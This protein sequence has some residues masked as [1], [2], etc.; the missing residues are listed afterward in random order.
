LATEPAVCPPQRT[1]PVNQ[2]WV[3]RIGSRMTHENACFIT[4]RI[5]TSSSF[6]FAIIRPDCK[7][8][9][10]PTAEAAGTRECWE[11]T[12]HHRFT[13]NPGM[14]TARCDRPCSAV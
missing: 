3:T 10:A 1:Y 6:V 13:V 12:T 8:A 2:F 14:P 5:D 11:L 7:A 4:G 9:Q